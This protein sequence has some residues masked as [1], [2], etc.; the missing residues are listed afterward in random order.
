MKLITVALAV[1]AGIVALVLWPWVMTF[2]GPLSPNPSDWGIFGDYVNGAISPL[3]GALAFIALLYTVKQQQIQIEQLSRN[4]EREATFEIIRCIEE[5]F[6]EALELYPVILVVEG[7]RI[8]Y[9]GKEVVFN[10]T[11]KEYKQAILNQEDITKIAQ[12][13]TAIPRDDWRIPAFEMFGLAA[14]HLNQ[15]RIYVEHYDAL[16]K[17]NL[18]SKYYQRKYRVPY[19]RFVER[20]VLKTP[21]ETNLTLPSSGP[22]TSAA[23]G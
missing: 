3:V 5:D 10:P 1:V 17:N 16:A 11:F 9:S 19:R 22:A 20:G 23:E 8:E 15:L 18:M 12:E 4:A 6:S 7:R 13:S 14:G 21:W 2:H